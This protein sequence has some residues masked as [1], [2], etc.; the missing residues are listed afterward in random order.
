MSW[1]NSETPPNV[2]V[3][4]QPKLSK[5]ASA[6]AELCQLPRLAFSLCC[7]LAAEARARAG[8]AVHECI[9]LDRQTQGLITHS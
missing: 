5:L 4:L 9:A 2:S 8:V 6:G 3:G 7:S 1:W